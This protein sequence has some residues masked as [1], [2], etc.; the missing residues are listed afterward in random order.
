MRERAGRRH[1]PIPFLWNDIAIDL[2]ERLDQVTHEFSDILFIGP[3][4]DFAAT[5]L[6]GRSGQSRFAA[7]ATSEAYDPQTVIIE[8]DRLPFDTGKFDLIITAGTLDSVNDLPGALVQIRRALRPDGLFLGHMFGAGSLATLKRAM[9]AADG[10]RPRPHVHPQ[11]DLRSAADLLT[12]AGFALPV[13]DVDSINVR[14]SSMA[15][16]IAD[17]R[18][19]GIGNAMAGKRGHLGRDYPARL[20]DAWMAFAQADGKVTEQFSHLYLSGWAPSPDQ[21]KPARRGSGKISLSSILPSKIGT[22]P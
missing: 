21:P 17:I 9:I 12:R 19:L 8:E 6:G 14:Y 2:A 10:D 7:L 13:A 15:R 5:I 3:I 16:L 1:Q 18:D 11:I 20:A 22:L 4:A